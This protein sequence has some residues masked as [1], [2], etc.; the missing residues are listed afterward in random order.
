[1]KGFL[2]TIPYEF[3]CMASLRWSGTPPLCHPVTCREPPSGIN[4]DYTFKTNTYQSRVTYTC[5]EG[6]RYDERV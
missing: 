5:L 3:Q 4:A 1:M 6:Y 2:P